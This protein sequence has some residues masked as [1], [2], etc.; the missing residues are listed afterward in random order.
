MKDKMKV[1]IVNVFWAIAATVA[2]LA[3]LYTA[4]GSGG[5]K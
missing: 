5:L 2:V 3:V 1:V 4:V